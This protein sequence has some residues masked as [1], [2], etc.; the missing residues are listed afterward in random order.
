MVQAGVVTNFAGFAGYGS[1]VVP[2]KTRLEGVLNPVEVV[3][4]FV[5]VIL[6]GD[7]GNLA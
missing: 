6:G 7:V 4:A 5:N 1:V 2:D 3:Q